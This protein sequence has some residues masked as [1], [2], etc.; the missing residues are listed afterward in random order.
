MIIISIDSN[1]VIHRRTVAAMAAL[2]ALGTS[3]AGCDKQPGGGQAN[4]RI[5]VV[6]AFYP[7]AFVTERIGG[8]RVQVTNLVAPGAEP[9]DL[10]LQ[11]EQATQLA[12]ADL[13]IYLRGFQPEVDKAIDQQG[14]SRAFDVATVEPLADPPPGVESE[15][16]K[17]PHVWLD[18]LRLLAFALKITDRLVQLDKTGE[19]AFFT[20]TNGLRSEVETLDKEYAQGLANC[21]RHEIVTS[22]AA[23]AYL[24]RRYHLTQI[25]ISGVSPEE[26]PTPQHLAEVAKLAREKGVTTIFFETLV[27]PKV[28]EALAREVGAKAEVLDPIEGLEQGS[29]EDYFSVM[30]NNLTKL[31][32][33]LGCT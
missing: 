21:Q 27:S 26:E 2:L 28:A 20:N 16:P 19:A 9:H 18:P 6:A 4:G 12:R 31:K 5:N 24:A 3:L 30:R 11:P 8:D 1:G 22:H 7:L 25:P 15:T 32:S 29:K 14:G 23:F 17:D 33:A 13:V 10:E